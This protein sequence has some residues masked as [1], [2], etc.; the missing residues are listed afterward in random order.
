MRRYSSV[1]EQRSCK[2]WVVGSIPTIG[3]ILY[4]LTTRFYEPKW[5]VSREASS[6]RSVLIEYTGR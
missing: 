6:N 5:V 4:V 1:V 3:S 2:P